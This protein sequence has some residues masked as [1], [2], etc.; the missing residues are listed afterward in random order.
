MIYGLDEYFANTICRLTLLGALYFVEL[1][2]GDSRSCRNTAPI[3]PFVRGFLIDVCDLLEIDTKR[4]SEV[5]LRKKGN[6]RAIKKKSPPISSCTLYYAF[7]I[8]FI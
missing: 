6:S 5:L 7:L 2:L 3:T 4:L 1:S 8:Q